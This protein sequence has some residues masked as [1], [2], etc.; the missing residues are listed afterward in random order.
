MQSCAW[1]FVWSVHYRPGN[2]RRPFTGHWVFT[3]QAPRQRLAFQIQ[4][5]VAHIRFMATQKNEVVQSSSV[6]FNSL[7]LRRS[8]KSHSGVFICYR[9]LLF[10][11]VK[12]KRCVFFYSGSI[13]YYK[14]SGSSCNQGWELLL[15]H[16]VPSGLLRRLYYI[17]QPSGRRWKQRGSTIFF[18]GCCSSK[19]ALDFV[20]Q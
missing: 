18:V 2:G 4:T 20:C 17:S 16:F 12:V 1:N 6:F 14:Q 9:I 13:S 5:L 3:G 10:S 7:L 11:F 8:L 19:Q 15:D